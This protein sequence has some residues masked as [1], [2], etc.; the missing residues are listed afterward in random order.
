MVQVIKPFGVS[1]WKVEIFVLVVGILQNDKELLHLAKYL[2]TF[3]NEKNLRT[4]E[5][6]LEKEN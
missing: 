2:L 1:E 5:K 3:Q 4:I 6:A